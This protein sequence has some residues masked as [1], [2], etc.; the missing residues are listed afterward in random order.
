MEPLYWGQPP[1]PGLSGRSSRKS[2]PNE[3]SPRLPPLGRKL[4]TEDIHAARQ[5]LVL[6]KARMQQ[7]RVGRQRERSSEPGRR[8]ASPGMG[9][10]TAANGR[11]GQRVHSM[12]P[13]PVASPEDS[14]VPAAAQY[15]SANPQGRR[16]PPQQPRDRRRQPSPRQQVQNPPEDNEAEWEPPPRSRPPM[17]FDNIPGAYPPGMEPPP[18]PPPFSAAKPGSRTAAPQQ[19]AAPDPFGPGAFPD[20][21]MPD[22]NAP[23][24]PRVK[25]DG[26]GRCFREAAMEKHA[27]ICKKVF[28]DKRKKFDSA[29]NRL[30]D[31]ENAAQLINN[32]KKIQEEAKAVSNDAG[33]GGG[34]G[35]GGKGNKPDAK[36]DDGKPMPAWKKK[37]LEFRA[38][39]LAQKA[40][41]GDAEAQAKVEE[42]K[43]ELK[44]APATVDP[45]KFQC[46]HCG[47]T[48]NK[49]AGERHVNICLK[50]FG[51]KATK[52]VRGGG[53]NCNA[54]PPKAPPAAAPAA[55]DR[56]PPPG[57]PPPAATASAATAG[58]R[59]RSVSAQRTQLPASNAAASAAL[60]RA[61]APDRTARPAQAPPR[62]AGSRGAL[63]RN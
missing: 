21:G 8:A 32:A 35:G 19:Q 49:E 42:M 61:A 57:R 28:Q 14:P 16:T 23:Q 25:C 56:E 53:K 40:A 43:E 15:Q 20:G 51:G 11:R 48:F 7:Q 6:L 5:H 33:G 2:T 39:M 4:S 59:G 46:P 26:C 55:A 60:D 63:S 1:Q 50:T 34:G 29:A 52:L 47:R 37:S 41:Q 45:D 3:A 9:E 12:P 54:G 62:R 17:D 22:E 24:S 44:T 31:Q 10:G 13:R 18:P 58:A 36:E 38:A 27:K 30:G